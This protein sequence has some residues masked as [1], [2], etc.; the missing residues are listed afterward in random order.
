MTATAPDLPPPPL[1]PFT[2]ATP[3]C[4]KSYHH[5]N[6]GL[7]RTAGSQASQC[8]ISADDHIQVSL[9]L[10]RCLCLYSIGFASATNGAPDF[11]LPTL[12]ALLICTTGCSFCPSLNPESSSG[13][14]GSLLISKC[15]KVA[16]VFIHLRPTRPLRSNPQTTKTQGRKKMEAGGNVCS[17][18]AVGHKPFQFIFVLVHSAFLRSSNRYRTEVRVSTHT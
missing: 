4:S 18:T 12:S 10:D 1:F 7:S 15:T 8:F 5:C 13:S 6:I 17:S 3:D 11:L 2:Q 14:T 9:G 16:E